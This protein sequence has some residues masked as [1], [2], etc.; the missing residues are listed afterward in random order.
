M[1]RIQRDSLGA[2]IKYEVWEDNFFLGATSSY[3]KAEKIL[4]DFSVHQHEFLRNYQE[5]KVPVEYGLR[6][7]D[8]EDPMNE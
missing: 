7:L 5:G 3:S 1:P 4:E 8:H 6:D 2:K